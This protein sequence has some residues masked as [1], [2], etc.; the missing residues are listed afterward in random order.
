MFLHSFFATKAD[1]YCNKYVFLQ[2]LSYSSQPNSCSV[3]AFMKTAIGQP[4]ADVIINVAVGYEPCI[5][6]T[7][8]CD[9]VEIATVE[10]CTLYSFAVHLGGEGSVPLYKNADSNDSASQL[11]S[12]A[13]THETHQLRHSCGSKALQWERIRL[14]WAIFTMRHLFDGE[15]H[16]AAASE[17]ARLP[18][19]P[20]SIF[21]VFN[22]LMEP[23]RLLR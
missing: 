18:S 3:L 13:P 10:D 23:S 12:M 6:H 11:W 22:D 9:I 4:P 1:Y 7:T 5:R 16:A 17:Q 2:A 15:K 19:Q 21:D 14:R 8:P 20:T